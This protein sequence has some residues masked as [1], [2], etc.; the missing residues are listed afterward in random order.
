MLPWAPM[1]INVFVL[2]RFYRQILAF[3][4]ARFSGSDMLA[5]KWGDM[6]DRTTYI[7]KP[8]ASK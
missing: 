5:L 4:A 8:L 2:P 7:D 3:H 1:L 6:S